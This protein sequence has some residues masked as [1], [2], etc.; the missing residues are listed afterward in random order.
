M[1]VINKEPI[2]VDFGNSDQDG[3]VR[4]ITNG[5]KA[6]IERMKLVLIEGQQIWLTDNEVEMKGTLT[7]R[8][9]IWV[10]IPGPEGF[11]E[12]QKDAPHHLDNL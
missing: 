3:A 6:D 10:V 11:I 1:N 12:V 8:D 9:G 2:T 7:L 4:L 5:T